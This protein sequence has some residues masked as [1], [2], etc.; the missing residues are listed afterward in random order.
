M[1]G[2]SPHKK[3]IV[4]GSTQSPQNRSVLV[5]DNEAETGG[6]SYFVPRRRGQQFRA[7][8]D[9]LYRRKWTILVCL[10]VGIAAVALYAFTQPPEHR[11]DSLVL[12]NLSSQ[13]E[14]YWRS[15]AAQEE[16]L[17]P[18][19]RSMFATNDRTLSGEL[20]LLQTSLAIPQRVAGRLDEMKAATPEAETPQGYVRFT[21]ASEGINVIQVT[22]ISPDPKHA[23]LLANLYAEEYVRLTQESSRSFLSA[24]RRSLEQEEQRRRVQLDQSEVALNSYM[25]EQR[26]VSLDR[27]SAFLV[28]QIATLETELGEVRIDLQSLKISLQGLEEELQQISPQLT[29]RIV[30]SGVQ[31]RIADLQKR[32]ADLEADKEEILLR[33]P[34]LR[35]S[36]ANNTDSEL[37]PINQKIQRLQQ[38]LKDL[39][40]QYVEEVVAAGGIAAGETGLNYIAEL[41]QRAVQTQSSISAKEATIQVM[42]S[43]LAT[44]QAELDRLPGQQMRLAQLERGRQQAEQMYQSVVQR[45][46]QVRLEEESQPGYAQVLRQASEP[47]LPVSPDPKRLLVLGAVFGLLLGIGVALMLDQLDNRIYKAD[48]LEEQGYST[49]GVVPNLKPLIKRSFNGAAFVD[50]DGQRLATSLIT[51]LYP[52]SPIAE[53]YRHIGTNIQFTSPSTPGQTLLITSPNV[54]EGKSTLASNLAIAMVHVGRRVLLIDADLRRP[55]LHTLFGLHRRVGLEQLLGGVS[56]LD[57]ETL[58]TNFENLYVLTARGVSA[59]ASDAARPPLNPVDLL[60]PESIRQALGSLRHQFDLIIVDAPPVLV[61]TDAMILSTQ[62][63]ATLLLVRAGKTKETELDESM[64]ILERV[65]T[66]VIGTVLN[67]FDITMAYGQ[68]YKYQHYSTY[69]H[70][71]QNGYYTYPTRTS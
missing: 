6:F 23:V 35:E 20:F 59:H 14:Q 45:L 37:L 58:R 34:K 33:Y 32:I 24:S 63:D 66:T 5:D 57:M 12:V 70:Y 50:K 19:G 44:Y 16:Q 2:S 9:V 17:V 38:Q 40:Q 15:Y 67:G 54:E 11:A 53:A 3:A 55:K 65:G 26:A 21:E 1:E 29:R 60:R 25:S 62:C 4:Y 68:R 51:P 18:D 7:Y 43:R 49:I 10:Q 64:R 28:G 39:A 52:M 30:A 69:G 13:W 56:D 48:Q 8:I 46:Q 22:A 41:K 47:A 31:Q 27:E 42:E 36:E 61:A 71:P